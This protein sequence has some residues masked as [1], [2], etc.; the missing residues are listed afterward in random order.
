MMEIVE[1]IRL[2]KEVQDQGEEI[3]M[4]QI[5]AFK[6]LKWVS[7]KL[8]FSTMLSSALSIMENLPLSYVIRSQT[9]PTAEALAE[10]PLDQQRLW[11]VLLRGS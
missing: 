11:S 2:E 9:P 1:N 5:P 3:A 10:M 4:D 6:P 8:A 7:W